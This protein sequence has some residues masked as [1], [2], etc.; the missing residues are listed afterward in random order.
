MIISST[1]LYNE[2]IYLLILKSDKDVDVHEVEIESYLTVTLDHDITRTNIVE[3]NRL[4][5]FFGDYVKI[6]KSLRRLK[7]KDDVLIFMKMEKDGVNELACEFL[8]ENNDKH[9]LSL[10]H[11][12]ES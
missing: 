3:N 8:N 4:H 2:I 6:Q 1:F 5:A 9:V 12:S 11:E 7:L 10:N